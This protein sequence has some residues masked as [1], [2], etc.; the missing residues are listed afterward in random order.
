MPHPSGIEFDKMLSCAWSKDHELHRSNQIA[1][2]RGVNSMSSKDALKGDTSFFAAEHLGMIGKVVLPMPVYARIKS[3]SLL[4]YPEECCG[5]LIG[6]RAC[7]NMWEVT[8]AYP[9]TNSNRERRRDRYE[10]KPHVILT[11]TLGAKAQGLE[12]IGV[13]HSHP[14]VPPI[15]SPIDGM[16]AWEGLIYLIA[17]VSGEGSVKM[18]AWLYTGEIANGFKNNFAELEVIVP[19]DSLRTL[20]GQNEIAISAEVQIDLRGEVLPFNIIQTKKKLEH[21][22][23]GQ[24]LSILLDCERSLKQLPEALE[25]DGHY[26]L[27]IRQLKECQWEIII[28]RGYTGADGGSRTRTGFSPTGS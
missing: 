22:Q 17:S 24:V 12:W 18:R 21:M 1:F 27:C 15:P 16:L 8:K 11:A 9:A 13:Y 5:L 25:D 20:T 3:H 6:R 4:A 10:I 14:D 19:I 28:K 7:E 2:R 26:V 23:P